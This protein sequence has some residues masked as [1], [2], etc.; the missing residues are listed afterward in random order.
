[1]GTE[2][3]KIKSVQGF[4]CDDGSSESQ[5]LVPQKMM[6]GLS[7]QSLKLRQYSSKT[8]QTVTFKTRVSNWVAALQA[9]FKG[10]CD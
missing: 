8:F 9:T 7:E 6:V 3:V 5:G 4:F 1:M 2:E 10:S